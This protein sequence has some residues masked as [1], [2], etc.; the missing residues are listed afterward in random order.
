MVEINGIMYELKYNMK[1]LE[2]I[3]TNLKEGVLATIRRNEGLLSIPTLKVM[4]GFALYTDTG[5]RISPQQGIDVIENWICEAGFVAVNEEI[6][7]AIDRDCP[8]LFKVG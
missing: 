8:F 3:E 1:T 6:V 7:T 2:Q 5:N 4:G